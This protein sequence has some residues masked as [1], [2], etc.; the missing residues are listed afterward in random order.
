MAVRIGSNISALTVQRS[1]SKTSKEL[2]SVSERLSSGLRINRGSDDAAGLSVAGGLKTDRRVFTQGVR[3]LNDGLSMLAVAE[4]AIGQLSNIVIR[5][6]E[7]AEQAA[8]GIFSPSQRGALDLEAQRLFDEYQRILDTTEFNGLNLLDGSA[9]SIDLQAGYGENGTIQADII[10]NSI[11][12]VSESI[13]LGTYTDNI[14]SYGVATADFGPEFIV[15]DFNLDGID[16]VMAIKSRDLGSTIRTSIGFLLGNSTGTGY[17]VVEPTG[18]DT[19]YS[20]ALL[21]FNVT[22][23]ARDAGSDGDSDLIVNLAYITSLGIGVANGTITNNTVGGGGFSMGAFVFDGTN[24]TIDQLSASVTADMNN[25]GVD[26]NIQGSGADV[27]VRIQDTT[28][29]VTESVVVE[30]LAQDAF[31]LTSQ[32]GALQALS[33]LKE[34]LTRI[35]SAVARIGATQS[36]IGTAANVITTN[37]E[38][39]AAAQSRIM[40][41]DIASE[42][43]KFVKLNLL[44]QASASILA[45]ANLQPQLALNLIQNAI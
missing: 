41:A 45:Q 36:K 26:D 19:I 37:V 2:H 16:D 12:S 13:G 44:Q 31:S 29:N 39:Y 11:D 33:S 22:A 28:V 7:L 5:Q 23:Q 32:Y 27:N 17:T 38:N 1:L 6:T 18:F 30:S 4:G 10:E 20:G 8:N 42:S 9:P 24:V 15:A 40:D 21:N 25:D 3:N 43:A 14:V 34:N 35:N